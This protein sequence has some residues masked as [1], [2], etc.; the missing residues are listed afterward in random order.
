MSRPLFGEVLPT[1]QFTSSSGRTTKTSQRRNLQGS[2]EDSDRRYR[3]ARDGTRREERN[4]TGNLLSISKERRDNSRARVPELNIV[5]DFSKPLNRASQK[6]TDPRDVRVKKIGSRQHPIQNS[7]KG[8]LGSLRAQSNDPKSAVSPSDRFLVIG[9]SVPS[10]KLAEHMSSPDSAQTQVVEVKDW[11]DQRLSPGTPDIVITPAKEEKL[12]FPRGGGLAPPKPRRRATSSIYSVATQFARGVSVIGDAARP[13][14]P[15]RIF[16]APVPTAARTTR[17]RV[18]SI[19]TVFDEDDNVRGLDRP[20]SGDS[21]EGFLRRGSFD[22]IATRDKSQGWWNHRIISPLLGRTP[23]AKSRASPLDSPRFAYFRDLTRPRSLSGPDKVSP[24]DRLPVLSPDSIAPPSSKFNEFVG[25]GEASE[26]YE[27]S[28]HDMHSLIRYFECQ[29]HDCSISV[30]AFSEPRGIDELPIDSGDSR[31]LNE[32]DTSSIDATAQVTRSD[33][34]DKFEETSR[35]VVPGSTFQQKPANRFSAAFAEARGDK[36]RPMSDVTDIEEDPET[37]PEVAEALVAP[38][39]KAQPPVQQTPPSAPQNFV[40]KARGFSPNKDLPSNNDSL[41]DAQNATQIRGSPP[42]NIHAFDSPRKAPLTPPKPIPTANLPLQPPASKSLPTTSPEM[43]RKQADFDEIP[44]TRLDPEP[45][46]PP[47]IQHVYN[48]NQFYHERP[49]G[50]DHFEPAVL[51]SHNPT[52]PPSNSRT[53][54]MQEKGKK[55]KEAELPPRIKKD[56]AFD[57]LLAR[58]G[59]FGRGKIR[60]KKSKRQLHCWITIILLA[61]VILILALVM[62]L[63]RKTIDHTPVQTQWLNLTGFPP[64]PT[65]IS[66]VAR[67]DA[68]NEQSGCVQPATMWSCAVPKEQQQALAPNDPDQPNFRLEILYQNGSSAFNNTPASRLKRSRAFTPASIWR[69]QSQLFNPNPA[70]PSLQDQIFLGNTTDN[71]TNP[72]NGESTPFFISFLSTTDPNPAKKLKFRK[73]QE[74]SNSSNSS[75]DPFPD[76]TSN[77]PPPDLNTDGTAAPANLLPFPTAQPLRLYNRGLETE[78]YGFY[79]YFDRS[80]F[81]RSTAL[82]NLNATT[83]TEVPADLNGGAEESAATVRCTWRQTRLLVQIWTNQ[84]GTTQLLPFLNDT[85]ASSSS[86]SS[87]SLSSSSTNSS[88]TDF[89]RPGSFPYPITI[90]LDRHGGDVSTKEIYCYGIDEAEHVVQNERKIQLE[91][92]AFG[93]PGLINAAMGAFG[94]VTVGGGPGQFGGIDGGNGGCSCGWRNWEGRQ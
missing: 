40:T 64:I 49:P 62:T 42:A 33:E 7:L 58:L 18:L 28:Y 77:I 57:K 51:P 44:L 39:V 93:G 67:P 19:D 86:S 22:T 89:S 36:A 10:S 12:V 94:N 37:T 4:G 15:H 24:M 31:G 73:R 41:S 34:E 80:I 88:A 3:K 32:K 76:I 47:P 2:S 13:P 21:Q 30:S 71:T 43:P 60:D 53:E 52:H 90:I 23:T 74:S 5:T 38:V 84:A 78:H 16:T 66:T 70:P 26:Y 82:I 46:R 6:G 55:A 65:G 25:L 11:S 92:R 29:G 27:A 45:A 63:T 69:R 20:R 72:F 1:D 17:P 83:V 8:R 54:V 48:I 85:S 59:C 50:I 75:S 14:L 61:I 79:T 56:S 91:N 35:D 68:Y 81:L 87:S 9:I